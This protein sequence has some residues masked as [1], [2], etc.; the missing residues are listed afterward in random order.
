MMNLYHGSEASKIGVLAVDALCWD[1]F[2]AASERFRPTIPSFSSA[3]FTAGLAHDPLRK[4]KQPWLWVGLGS[5][6]TVV[7]SGQSLVTQSSK[8]TRQPVL[9]GTAP[10]ATLAKLLSHG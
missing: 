7:I 8:I 1:W 3:G 4:N 9:F 5:H 10:I 2:S 6:V